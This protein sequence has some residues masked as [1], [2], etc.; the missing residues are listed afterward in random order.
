[1]IYEIIRDLIDTGRRIRHFFRAF[2]CKH[3]DGGLC[4]VSIVY[5]NCCL[6]HGFCCYENCEK[7]RAKYDE[8]AD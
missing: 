1:M 7:R 2:F 3:Y 6:H 5:R 4:K 8:R